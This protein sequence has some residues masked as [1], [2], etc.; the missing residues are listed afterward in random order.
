MKCANYVAW[1]T[2]GA[3]W[4]RWLARRHEHR[5]PECGAVAR[6]LH[7][8]ADALTAS[9]P[10]PRQL[11]A[12]WTQALGEARAPALAWRT[13]AALGAAGVACV[14]LL[15]G[16]S[17]WWEWHGE[18][19]GHGPALV[20]M[21]PQTSPP[22]RSLDATQELNQLLQDVNRLRSQMSEL[23]QHAELMDARRRADQLLT[24]YSQW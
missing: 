10:L 15:I 13:L 23:A 18:G 22:L 2:T 9:E 8:I 1:R 19:P 3:W 21:N 7:A 4:Q 16:A 6:S 14:L 12:A 11:R 5:C 24:T 20:Q 17:A